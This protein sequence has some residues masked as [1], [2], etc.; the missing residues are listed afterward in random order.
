MNI[1]SFDVGIKHLA[2]CLIH[3]DSS[4]C[5]Y[6]IS[7]WDCINLCNLT[8][9]A[10]KTCDKAAIYSKNDMYYCKTHAKKQTNFLVPNVNLKKLKLSQL[11]TLVKQHHLDEKEET[12]PHKK[13]DLLEFLQQRFLEKVTSNANHMDL[14]QLGIN[15][16]N[17]FDELFQSD[18]IDY[19]LIENQISP[20]ATRM[21]TFQ[22]MITQ[23]FIMKDCYNVIYVSS[24]NKLKD[25][26]T[27]KLS[28]KER[29]TASI[30]VT[31][32][33]IKENEQLFLTWMDFYNK[34]KKKDDLADCYLQCLWFIKDHNLLK[35][36]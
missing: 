8:C 16:K 6:T 32:Q 18:K 29:K 30:D 33:Q 12:I 23:Y 25:F 7:S 15:M 17:S 5:T 13:A 21:K 9:Q 31:I 4:Q 10:D 26:I 28:Y 24:I 11:N 22:G 34:H 35:N 36:K 1:L 2:Y 3:I 27:K 19:V 14:I 20:I